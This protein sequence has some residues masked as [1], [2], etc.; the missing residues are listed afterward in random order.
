M[1][2]TLYAHPFSSYCQKVL[3]AL[4][5][6]ATPFAYRVLGPEDPAAGAEWAALWPLKR[7]PVLVDNGRSILE[8]STIIEYLALHHP[9]ENKLIPESPDAALEARMMDRVFDNY[10][11]TPMQKIVLDHLRP[12]GDRDSYGVKQA[13]GMLDTAYDWLDKRLDGQNWATGT[14]FTLADCAAAPSLFYADW[15]HEIGATRPRLS[16]YRAR[17]LAR[18]SIVRAVDEARPFRKFFPPGAPDR[19]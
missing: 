19:D 15:V 4:Y 7:M 12:E 3:I 18:P 2:L 5:E 8:S 10:I 17:L 13:R 1:Q 9:G 6:N 14:A 16:A 11:M